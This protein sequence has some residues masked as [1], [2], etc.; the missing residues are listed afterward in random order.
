[1]PNVTKHDNEQSK[2]ERIE[3]F[4]GEFFNC[5][6]NISCHYR[7]NYFW[8]KKEITSENAILRQNGLEIVN[9]EIFKFKVLL[10]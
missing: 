8:M 9:R 10:Q 5:A 2:I 1:M 4:I 6:D 3:N 7:A